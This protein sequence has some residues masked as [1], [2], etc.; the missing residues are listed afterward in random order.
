[1]KR[2]MREGESDRERKWGER[3][4]GREGEGRGG[5]RGRGEGE[6]GG[7]ERREEESHHSPQGLQSECQPP[8]RLVLSCQ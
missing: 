1:M 2:K 6:R 3:G 4:E 7:E 8:L 5:E